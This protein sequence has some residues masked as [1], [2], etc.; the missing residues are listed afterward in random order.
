MR[1]PV[2]I[3]SSWPPAT[4]PS[5]RRPTSELSS[6]KQR[7]QEEQPPKQPTRKR[8]A[9]SSPA[10]RRTDPKVN[11]FSA[12]QQTTDDRAEEAGF[13]RPEFLQYG[14]IDPRLICSV[15]TSTIPSSTLDSASVVSSRPAHLNNSTGPAPHSTI[16][17]TT[18]PSLMDSLEISGSADPDPLLPML[19]PSNPTSDERRLACEKMPGTGADGAV[20]QY[21]GRDYRYTFDATDWDSLSE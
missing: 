12:K 14:C 1:T 17:T 19:Q 4:R 21:P 9:S 16:P 3:S 2:S 5:S 15:E 18:C 20:I 7:P 10:G 11:P 8:Q 13:N 6:G